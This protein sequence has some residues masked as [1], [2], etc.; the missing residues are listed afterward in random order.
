MSITRMKK[1]ESQR[2]LLRASRAA[3]VCSLEQVSKRAL[4]CS[5]ASEQSRARCNQT[6]YLGHLFSPRS[7]RACSTRSKATSLR[8]R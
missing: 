6:F 1:R 4:L 5:A 7:R 3:T 2:S 8:Y